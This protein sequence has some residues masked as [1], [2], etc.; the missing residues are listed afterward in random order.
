MNSSDPPDNSAVAVAAEVG[1]GHRWMTVGSVE[2]VAEKREVGGL[3]LPRWAALV[4]ER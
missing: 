1:G 2:P 4:Q 3:I